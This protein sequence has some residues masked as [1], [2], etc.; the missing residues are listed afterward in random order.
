M[1]KV[2]PVHTSVLGDNKHA[3]G[4]FVLIK[5][6]DESMIFLNL[7]F[8]QESAEQPG[9][10]FFFFFSPDFYS[11][12]SSKP[13]HMLPSRIFC[14]NKLINTVCWA[15]TPILSSKNHSMNE[16]VLHGINT[17]LHIYEYIMY[18]IYCTYIFIYIH[19]YTYTNIHTKIYM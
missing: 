8:T 3:T 7:P 10:V 19:T 18:I 17:N 6:K 12:R 15:I 4:G 13:W 16:R 9:R 11:L 2:L 1:I 14:S 5:I